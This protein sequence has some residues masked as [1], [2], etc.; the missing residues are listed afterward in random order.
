MSK[1][2]L[3]NGRASLKEI[4]VFVKTFGTFEIFL[5][6]EAL[7]FGRSKAKE[8]LAYLIHKKGSY[9]TVAEIASVLWEGKDYN[10]SIQNQ[11]QVIISAMMKTLKDNDINDIIIKERN[12]I[13]I[14]KTKIKCDYYDFLNKDAGTIKSYDGKYMTNYSWAEITA[15]E[16]LS[17]KNKT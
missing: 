3:D 10:R 8:T 12:R 1:L 17:R 4:K 13:S 16:L 6:G 5:Y 14:D 11:T 2:A 9:S 15:G 7:V